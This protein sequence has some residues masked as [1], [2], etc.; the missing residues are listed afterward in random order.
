MADFDL[1]IR[2]GM[3]HDGLGGAPRRAD[4]AVKDGRIAAIGEVS[5]TATEVMQAGGLIVT[6][7]FVDVHTHY[8]G[9]ATW[10][11]RLAPSSGHGVTSVVMGNC[12]VGFA[13][14]KPEQRDIL[15]KVMEGVEDVPEVVM[16]EG[17]PWNW[18]TFPQYLDALEARSFDIDVA[19]QL[20]HS[21]LRVFVMGER[22]AS[23]E[24]PSADDLAQMRR[25][26]T[27][28]IQ[29]GALGVSTSR[30][31]LHRTKAG[32]LAPSLF[33]EEDELAALAEGLKDA[34]RGVFQIIPA[35]MGDARSEFALMRRLAE[36]SGRPLSYTLIQMPAGDPDAWRQSL[37]ALSAA[38]NDG[39]QMRAQV[40]PRPVGMFYGLDLS[41]HPFAYHPSYKAIAHLPRSERVARMKDPHFRAQLLSEQPEDTNTVNVKTVKS[42]QYAYVWGD[43]PNY[44]PELADRIDQRAKAA[45]LSVEEYVYDMLLANDGKAIFYQPGANYRD[46][47]LN[48][49]REMLGHP[50]SVVGLAD[51]GAHYGMICDASFPTYFL[52]RWARDASEAQ[53]I[54]L[55]KA[56]AALTSEPAA[57][58]GLNDRGRL[59]VGLKA[60]I[61]LI[62]LD[63]L[64]VHVP[65][66]VYDLPAG[67]RRM[68]QLADGYVATIV[69]GKVTYRNGEH[70]GELPGRLVRGQR[71]APV[72]TA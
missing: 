2:G 19:A 53:R 48:A 11:N 61:N 17:L 25:L 59:A 39:L 72:V 4:V 24:P 29:A 28:A 62:D 55:P 68:R 1:I 56:I 14:C 46:R 58:A 21:A 5:G 35:P 65:S 47:N 15:V 12:G 38:A 37:E 51:G 7:G 36:R 20:P 60:D 31:L 22:A 26:T 27:E 43:N 42:F 41:F 9:Q 52:A 64:K 34:G 18:E 16:T 3:V 8:D 67:G 30:N 69:S 33:S 50:Q 57:L 63:R 6:P 44:E 32:E 49:V 40:A 10:E 54:E 13:P 71:E 45:N 23:S 66:V 70:T